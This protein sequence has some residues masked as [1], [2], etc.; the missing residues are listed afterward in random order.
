MQKICDTTVGGSISLNFYFYSCI[1]V[2][3]MKFVWLHLDVS[4]CMEELEETP[5]AG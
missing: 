4:K 2:Y 5:A 1:N 3:K